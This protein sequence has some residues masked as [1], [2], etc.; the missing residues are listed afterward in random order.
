MSQ[1]KVSSSSQDLY[2]RNNDLSKGEANYITQRATKNELAY[3][4]YFSL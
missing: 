1:G 4:P 3:F 2:K